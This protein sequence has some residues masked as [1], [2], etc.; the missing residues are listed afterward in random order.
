MP[1]N[2]DNY[3]MQPQNDSRNKSKNI[4]IKLKKRLKKPKSSAGCHIKQF[5]D[6]KRREFIL[7]LLDTH[8]YHA[9]AHYNH[10]DNH[11]YIHQSICVF[12]IIMPHTKGNLRKLHKKKIAE[13]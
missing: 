4:Y 11:H 6:G 1:I 10:V 5:I 9:N 7:F 3:L 8:N 2:Y 13:N 12:T